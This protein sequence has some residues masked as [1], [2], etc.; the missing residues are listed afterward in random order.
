ML[1]LPEQTVCPVWS[2]CCPCRRS[3]CLHN[4]LHHPAG[5]TECCCGSGLEAPQ[6]HSWRPLQLQLPSLSRVPSLEQ[7]TEPL[8]QPKTHLY[9]VLLPAIRPHTPL[10]QTSLTLNLGEL[11]FSRINEK[12]TDFGGPENISFC[13]LQYT[14]IKLGKRSCTNLYLKHLCVKQVS[15]W[16][17]LLD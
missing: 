11:Y 3:A 16:L 12:D 1:T 8:F 14:T 4:P 6:A 17:L 15:S 10:L 13:G 9:A 5:G 2:T 7:T